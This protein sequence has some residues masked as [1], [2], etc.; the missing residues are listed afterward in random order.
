MIIYQYVPIAVRRV[1]M[2]PIHVTN[3]KELCIAMPLAKRSI[4]ISIRKIVREE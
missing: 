4:D 2:L 1:V 3:A